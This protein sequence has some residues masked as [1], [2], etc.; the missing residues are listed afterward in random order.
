MA[1]FISE[2]QIEQAILQKLHTQYGFEVLNCF[3]QNPEDLNDRSNRTHKRDVILEDRL[4]EASIRLNPSIPEPVVDLAVA[5]L[6]DKRQA[7]SLVAANR[8]IDA[9]IRDG[10]PVEYEAPDG[11][12]VRDRVRVIDFSD[13]WA[14]RFLAVSQLW[15]KGEIYFRRSGC[16]MMLSIRAWPFA[17]KKRSIL[18][19]F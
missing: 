6:T 15:I 12:K 14:N 11:K 8:E 9:L 10:I 4:K 18:P 7:M 3:T 13:P 5:R 16:W 2:D 1:N 17:W 19:A